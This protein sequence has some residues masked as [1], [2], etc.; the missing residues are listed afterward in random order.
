MSTAHFLRPTRVAVAT[1][2][3]AAL[4]ACGSGQDEPPS[5]E[6]SEQAAK[7][8]DRDPED[9]LPEIQCPEGADYRFQKTAEGMEQY[10]E[11]IGVLHGPFRRWK[12]YETKLVDG[13]YGGGLPSG[14]W[15]WNYDSGD[16]KSR[17]SYRAGKQIGAWA[18]WHEDGSRAE[19]G[20]FLAGHKAGLWTSWF[21]SGKKQ[22]EGLYRNGEK[23]GDW[24]SFRSRIQTQWL[25]NSCSSPGF[26]A[27]TL[28]CLHYIVFRIGWV[29]YN[30]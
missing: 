20:D 24:Y 26:C 6:P 16:R 19:E 2:T 8:V 18:W 10:C 9:T 17:G 28:Y 3:L 27:I 30:T 11:N 22:D 25:S 13:E 7:A 21:S 15:S 14:L 5:P 4:V 12:D 29:H 23:H 1:C